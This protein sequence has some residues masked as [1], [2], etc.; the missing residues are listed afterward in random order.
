MLI[1]ILIAAAL[2]IGFNF[3]PVTGYVRFILYLIPYLII[4]YDILIK[5]FI[6]R[7]LRVT[8]QHSNGFIH[9][10]IFRPCFKLQIY[11][12]G[13]EIITWKSLYSQ[14]LRWF[15]LHKRHIFNNSCELIAIKIDIKQS[16]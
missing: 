14:T 1:R 7:M 4:G 5:A 15:F 9:K 2:L 8:C 6:L 10:I 11:Y 13:V 12:T 3:L 16:S